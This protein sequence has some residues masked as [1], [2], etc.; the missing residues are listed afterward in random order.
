MASPAEP[1]LARLC[2][3][4]G[5]VAARSVCKALLPLNSPL[6][7]AT[8]PI[9]CRG[10]FA[11]VKRAQHR[12]DKSEWAVKCID[13]AKLDKEDEEA[14]KVEVE[15]LS[16]VNHPNIVKMRQVFDT[17]RTFYMVMEIMTGGEMF[18]RI[19][20]KSKYSESEAAAVVA[21]I[22]G[23]LVYCHQ[24]GIVHRD[25]KVSPQLQRFF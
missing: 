13:K 17:P 2:P 24:R 12:V 8:C 21:K 11:I 18:D 6:A 1:R 3:P 19:V 16:K 22:A 7:Y 20:A 9:P 10:S 4:T 5:S 23:A 25:L 14:L 15:I